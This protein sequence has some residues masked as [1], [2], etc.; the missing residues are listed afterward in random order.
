MQVTPLKEFEDLIF[1]GNNFG[2]R[3]SLLKILRFWVELR[4]VSSPAFSLI[5][6]HYADH[7]QLVSTFEGWGKLCLCLRLGRR[8]V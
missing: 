5:E 8:L 2:S 3:L 4:T 1:Q 6:R 7:G